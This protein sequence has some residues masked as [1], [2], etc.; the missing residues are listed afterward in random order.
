ME[1]KTS[2][3]MNAFETL[4]FTELA[5]HKKRKMRE[6]IDIIDLSVGSPDAPP[7]EFIRNILSKAVLN[8]NEYGYSLSGSHEFHLAVCQYYHRKFQVHLNP[9]TEVIQ[10]MGSQDGLVHFPM[11][12]VNEGDIVLLPDPGYPAYEAGAKLA[13]ATIYPL[14]LLERN[15]FLPDLDHIPGEIAEK[16]KMLI[17]NFPGNPVPALAT[18]AFFEKVVR[19]A[20]QYQIMVVHDFAYSELIFDGRKGISFLSVEGAKDVG[21]EFNSLSKSFNMAGCRIGYIVGNEE[22]IRQFARF[23]SNLDYGV[24]API[25]Q[26]AAAALT[27]GDQFLDLNRSMYEKRRDLLADGLKAI[28]WDVEAPK[29]TMFMWAKIPKP[30]KSREFA[31]ELI[32]RAGVVVTPGSAFGQH[33]EGYVRIALVQPEARLK[34]AVERIDRSGLLRV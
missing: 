26:A 3:K 19:F 29:A 11:A 15:S 10:T 24:F 20:K 21:V 14:P 23:K 22:I 13:G 7:P 6:G 18:K 31:L 1:I 12:F 30:I 17:L 28:G 8:E 27:D 16:A 9:S 34:E 2:K 4:I 25:Q 32:E 5:Y 33:G